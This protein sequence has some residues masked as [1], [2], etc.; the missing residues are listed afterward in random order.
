MA[1]RRESHT[2]SRVPAVEMKRSAFDRSHGLKTT[3]DAGYLVP[4]FVDEVVPGD[5]HRVNAN[6]FAR[7]AT[8]QKPIMDNLYLETFFFFVPF[9]LLWD[10]HQRFWGEQDNPGDSTD[11]LV[12]Q[13]VAPPGAAAT[14]G[15][16]WDYLG[17]PIGVPDL[18]MSAFYPRAYNKVYNDWFR[19][20]N[21]QDSV[22]ENRGDGPDDPS[23][24]VLLR[25][26]KRHDY[27]TSALP[28]PQKGPEVIMPISGAVVTGMQSGDA[29]YVDGVP[30]FNIPNANPPIV[31]DPLTV[32]SN[33]TA[34]FANYGTNAW[35]PG[36]VGAFPVPWADPQ[37]IVGST[38]SGATINDFR[39]A[40]VIQQFY[41]MLARGGS[42]YVEI[43]RSIYGVTNGDARL[44]RSEYLGGGRTNVM[45]NPVV[46]TAGVSG[47][48]TQGDLAAYGVGSS[49]SGHGFSKAFTEHGCVIGLACVRADL[50]YQQGMPRMY[51]RRERFD[52]LVPHFANLGEQAILNEEIYAQGSAVLN[53]QGTPV[54]K[55]VFG[56]VSRYDDYRYKPSQVTGV[57]RSSAPTSIDIWHLAQDF[58]SLPA[59]S[60]EFIVENPPVDRIIA[61]PT[62][63]Q[64][65][66]DA[67]IQLQSVREL[68]V[69]SVPGL[70]RI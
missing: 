1:K 55:D 58:A 25:R 22:P 67:W 63:P 23:D 51:S 43:L 8:L 3:F 5:H 19:D 56:Y 54:D 20:Q 13:V 50:N 32:I 6:L 46:N 40:V 49:G 24:Y 70:R 42:R 38:P 7:L 61:A 44:Q 34:G 30:H 27:F 17:V 15:S 28:W 41:E 12:P 45:V 26:G 14:V 39:Q 11:Y 66:M 36:V 37:L 21:L 64:F 2:F 16:L 62:E 35:G 69:Y 59:L 33:G 29:G 68:P 48:N 57:F 47:G 18:A 4:I 60:P 31:D 65:L 53:P 52:F 10:N 9:R